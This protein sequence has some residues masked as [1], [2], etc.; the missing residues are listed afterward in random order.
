MTTAARLLEKIGF[1]Y[2]RFSLAIDDEIIARGGARDRTTRQAVGLEINRT[3][4]QRW[5]CEKV[6]ERDK[7]MC[8]ACGTDCP[9]AYYHLKRL[10]GA[11]RA[12]A[13]REWG[14]KSNSRRTLW[15]NLRG[16]RAH[17][18]SKK[19]QGCSL[20]RYA[21]TAGRSRVSRAL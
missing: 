13:W 14:I 4:G 15:D 20:T 8:A 21:I 18:R 6:L 17:S 11:A 2:T 1:A 3:K 7:G 5:L 12:R 16:D 9:A 10:R 19:E